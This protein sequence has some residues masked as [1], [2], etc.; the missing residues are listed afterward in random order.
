[1]A[2]RNRYDEELRDADLGGYYARDPHP[3][4]FG[5]DYARERW[6]GGSGARG[7]SAG[8]QSRNGYGHVA[9]GYGPAQGRSTYGYN[10]NGGSAARYGEMSYRGRG[11]KNYQRSDELIADDI[12]RELT[13]DHDLDATHIDVSV[14]N[15]EVTLTGIVSSRWA[16]RHA[17]DVVAECR[18]VRDVQNRLRIEPIENQTIGKASE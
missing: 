10:D 7:D 15:G 2:N 3:R 5:G 11:P 4:D 1:M 8:E 12:H 9:V 17:E 13:D 18:G 14:Q 16:K 6:W